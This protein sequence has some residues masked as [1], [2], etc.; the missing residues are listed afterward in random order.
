MRH[1]FSDLTP[2]R[3]D[4][5]ELMMQRATLSSQAIERLRLGPHPVWLVTDPEAVKP[6]L[7]APEDEIDK[8]R[9]IYKLRQVMGLSSL[10]MS[11][12]EHRRRRGVLHATFAKG[13][14]QQYVPEMSAVIR[15]MA[16]RLLGESSFD[17]HQ[18]TSRLSLRL[19]SLVM[20]GKDVLTEG[21]EQVIVEAVSLVEDDLADELFR[22]IPLTP[23]ERK[24]REQRRAFANE[25]MSLVVRRVRRDAPSTSAVR[26][27]EELGLD[28]V[29]MRDEVL[30]MILA[31]YHTT[32]S[33][34]A[35]LFYHLATEG[36]ALEA[37]RAEAGNL[38]KRTG[39]IS[40]EGLATARTSLAFA[41]E[42]LRLYPSSHWFS[43]DAKA[44]VEIC[45]HRLR[46][47]DSILVSP[48][49][50]HRS[51]RWWPN[52]DSFDLNRDFASKAFIPFGAGP[53]V[54]VGMGVVMLELQLMAI[55]L[56]AAFDLKV[57]SQVP[58]AKPKSSI[59]LVPPP[60]SMRLK[61][62]SEVER[63]RVAA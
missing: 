21:D 51:P 17:A 13:A 38:L 44:D 29:A 45:G 53:R 11:G 27:L 54:C 20:F 63:Q 22:V 39:E 31:G 14:A 48:W 24:R 50:F 16:L 1:W 4:P 7:K 34:A 56:A 40:V 61:L 2:F 37:V 58:A 5:L 23:W 6:V 28:D 52:P 10:S 46:K 62:R 25:A 15:R 43:R 47:G 59:T 32:G 57:V 35:W 55:E 30:T 42:T 19:I 36:S 3:R 12:D 8:G 41:R 18:A 33:V 9:F 60:I 26:A 49:A